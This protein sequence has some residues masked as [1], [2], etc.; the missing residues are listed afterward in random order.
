MKIIDFRV[1]PPY[2]KYL[3]TGFFADI[4]FREKVASGKYNM[5]CLLYTSYKRVQW[6]NGC[7]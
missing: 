2:G 4:P 7:N 6:E 3:E 1:R 5:T